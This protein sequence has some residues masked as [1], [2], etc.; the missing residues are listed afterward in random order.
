MLG[1]ALDFRFLP[2]PP[3]FCQGSQLWCRRPAQGNPRPRRHC[4]G[5]VPS[6]WC[7]ERVALRPSRIGQAVTCDGFDAAP[8][9]RYG[10]SRSSGWRRAAGR[11][12]DAVLD[13]RL[14][15]PEGLRADGQA[16]RLVA[17]DPQH[18]GP[19][20][21]IELG[22]FEDV[23]GHRHPV[24]SCHPVHRSWMV[25]RGPLRFAVV[26]WCGK[27]RPAGSGTWGGQEPMRR[28]S[29]RPGCRGAFPAAR[30][31]PL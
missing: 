13:G 15:I 31:L 22:G 18:H 3:L 24:G 10:R 30:R 21:P 7:A 23:G 9:P 12:G 1:T 5:R 28:N 8:V 14:E 29:D 26:H 16:D 19:G 2:V 6:P 17:A 4:R 25:P 27:S 11:T 20:R